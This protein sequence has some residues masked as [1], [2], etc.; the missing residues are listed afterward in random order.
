ML[1]KLF[2]LKG[3]NTTLRTEVI[4][5]FTTFITMAYIIFVNPNILRM[6][7]M[8]SAGALGDDALAYNAFNDPV[9]GAV[10]V[11]TVLSS[12]LATLI[13]GLYA[14]YP[15]ALAP[16]MG[17]NAFFTF[18]V[19]IKMGY[20]WQ[21]ALG[22][23]FVSGIV[24]IIIT[25][26]GIREAIV[27]AI[28]LSLKNAV[29]AGIG[30][31]IALIGFSNAGIVVS[32]PAT[33]IGLGN[34]TEPH[35]L[36]AL[37]GLAITGILMA[38]K[39][40]GAIL[41][42][43]IIT[44]LLGIPAGIVSIPEGFTPVSLPP[45]LTPTFMK[46]DFKELFNLSGG[47]G[48][49]DAVIGFLGV[50]LAFTY[51]DLFDTLGTLV[52]TGAK[53]GM[54]DKEGR[55]PRINKALMADAVGTSAGALL[56]TSTVTTYIESA[57]GIMEGGKTGLTSV[58]VSLLFLASLFLAPVAGLVPAAATAPALIIVGVLMMGAVR[59]I[60]FSDFSE[61]LPAFMT[62]VIM[63]FSYSI[64][65]GIAA[66]LVFYPLVKVIS[67]RAREVHPIIYILAFL[68]I[69]RFATLAG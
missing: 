10:M 21:S 34:L 47:A 43:I 50:V 24:F 61:A 4:A 9:V 69:L 68:F 44:T 37:M 54:L 67:G 16:G 18:T 13:M 51:V 2:R 42:G 25:I 32:D 5:G 17:L 33:I 55:L 65:N 23:V 31:F 14:N 56:G 15:F 60:D 3:N 58:V 8:N 49:L 45:S 39:V 28:P 11:A 36:L 64:A 19:V 1:E 52:G 63:P 57:A 38:R 29:S 27:N 22:A 20:S 41:L 59:E 66:G 62:I 48:I 46:L 12:A 30:L 26:T 40:K 6:A 35:T 7:G 53:A